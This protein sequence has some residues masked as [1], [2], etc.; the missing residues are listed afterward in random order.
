MAVCLQKVNAAITSGSVSATIGSVTVTRYFGVEFTISV[1]R[2]LFR[3]V[4]NGDVS[5]CSKF[6]SACL[7]VDLQYILKIENGLSVW[8]VGWVIE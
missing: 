6:V 4:C 3:L 1:G 8:V 7:F 5:S 2:D